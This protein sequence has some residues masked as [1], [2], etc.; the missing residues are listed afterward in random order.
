MLKPIGKEHIYTAFTIAI[1]GTVEILA[2][3]HFNLIATT[4]TIVLLSARTWMCIMLA[5]D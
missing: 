1:V 3:R 5:K 4:G 2:L